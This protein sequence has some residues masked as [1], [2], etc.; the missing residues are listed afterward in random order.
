MTQLKSAN[1]NPEKRFESCPAC[2]AS[3]FHSF[4]KHSDVFEK[5]KT[6]R[7]FFYGPNSMLGP[8]SQCQD[9]GF[10]FLENPSNRT[11]EFYKAAEI[12][13]YLNLE[14]QRISYFRAV[15]KHA[16]RRHPNLAKYNQIVDFGCAAG[17]WLEVFGEDKTRIGIEL[18]PDFEEVLSH[19]NIKHVYD[20]DEI[21]TTQPLWI[22]A[23][24][25][26]EHM[27]DP[28]G[29]L[30]FLAK[31]PEASKNSYILGVPDVGRIWA[32][33]LGSNYYLYCPM[34][35]NYFDSHSLRLICERAFPEHNVDVY[36]SPLMFTNLKGVLKWIAPSL[37]NTAIGALNLPFGYR[38]NVMSVI[39]PKQGTARE[40]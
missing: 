40:L 25:F 17:N 39:T 19:K 3:S 37:T 7:E 6:W 21:E 35:F 12:D 28:L 34:H 15:K 20:Y 8:I 26:V 4:P 36:N 2:Q 27:E 29:F 33:L 5:P 1:P 23:F 10:H 24:D 32:K 18:N 9:C 38:A 30:Q 31:K 13:D 11:E 22:G 16:I 14:P